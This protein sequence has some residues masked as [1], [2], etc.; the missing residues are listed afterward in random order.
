MN[1]NGTE[2]FLEQFLEDL[3]IEGI[4]ST[5]YKYYE[6]LSRKAENAWLVQM[7]QDRV[8]EKEAFLH[9]DPEYSHQ[10]RV[11]TYRYGFDDG[12]LQH[13]LQQLQ[14]EFYRKMCAQNNSAIMSNQRKK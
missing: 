14:R 5:A 3:V 7:Y 11:L 2:K 12:V 9:N 13:A 1:T 8:K 6:T 10:I 4:G